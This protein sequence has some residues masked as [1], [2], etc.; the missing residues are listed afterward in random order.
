MGQEWCQLTLP[1]DT[2]PEVDTTSG[3]HSGADK[4]LCIDVRISGGIKINRYSNRHSINQMRAAFWRMV[5]E[6]WLDSRSSGIPGRLVMGE[7]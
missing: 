2:C 6:I 3:W 7:V 4:R 5:P 1:S